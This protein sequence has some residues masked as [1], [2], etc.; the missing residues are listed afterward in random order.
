M[1]DLEHGLDQLHSSVTSRWYFRLFTIFV[2]CLLAIGFIP[3][4]IP[5]IMHRPFTI[6]PDTNPVGAYF[7]ALYNTGFYYEFIGWSQLTAALLLLIPRTSHIGAFLFLPIIANI[8][9]LTCS[10]GFAGTWLVTI[11]MALAALWLTAWEYDR[12]KPLIFSDRTGRAKGSL[13]QFVWLPLLFAAGGGGIGFLWWLIRL[14]NFSNYA[15]VGAMLV[16]GGLIFGAV[17]AL[18]YRF[19]PVGRLREQREIL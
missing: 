13:I 1:F 14:G 12:F 7:H 17:V 4:S 9:V 15:Y 10:V 2:R 19:M 11:L 5:K 18:H 8:A 3:P 16:L 6:L